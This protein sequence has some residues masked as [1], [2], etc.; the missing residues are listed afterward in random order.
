MNN[1]TRRDVIPKKDSDQS[2]WTANAL[3][4][5]YG[6]NIRHAVGYNE[7]IKASLLTEKEKKFSA[8]QED[9]QK[10]CRWPEPVAWCWQ[11]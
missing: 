2:D 4:Q 8:V 9:R 1:K 10:E 7:V 5:S 11:C 6:G 3:D